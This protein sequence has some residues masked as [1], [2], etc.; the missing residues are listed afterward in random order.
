M[1]ANLRS[2]RFVDEET[3]A[4]DLLSDEHHATVNTLVRI[5]V[6][7]LAGLPIPAWAQEIANDHHRETQH[8]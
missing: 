5:G 4:L 7:I 6:R 2:V 8:R 3:Q 1:S